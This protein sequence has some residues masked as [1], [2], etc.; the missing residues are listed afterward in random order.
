MEPGPE[1]QYRNSTEHEYERPGQLIISHI[2][3]TRQPREEAKDPT[4]KP[5]VSRWKRK[6]KRW[7]KPMRLFTLGL[8]VVASLQWWVTLGQL[9]EMR[10]D[11]KQTDRL[12]EETKKL[13]KAAKEA[14]DAAVESNRL[15]RASL[16][17]TLAQGQRA[18]KT[19][20]ETSRL[21]QRPW[22]T[23]AR[24]SLSSELGEGKEI[25]V[26][27]WVQNTG[28]TPAVDQAGQSALYIWPTEPPA[29]NFTIPGASQMGIL[30]PGT[31][32]LSANSQKW[33]PHPHS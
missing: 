19:S 4:N 27:S 25:Y 7:T 17:A 8:L 10:S 20:I 23:F 26:E 12:I 24:F 5:Q 33:T 18:L 31:I 14:A 15:G 6:L 29:T 3:N 2:P 32:N 16:T 11:S 21:D 30:A 13:A 1:E 22:I 28:K 9:E